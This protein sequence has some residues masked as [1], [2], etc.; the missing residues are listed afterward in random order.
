MEFYQKCHF[1]VSFSKSE[2]GSIAGIPTI[3]IHGGRLAD[4]IQERERWLIRGK[5]EKNKK[6]G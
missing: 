5:S 4:F 3:S 1:G 2:V 6:G